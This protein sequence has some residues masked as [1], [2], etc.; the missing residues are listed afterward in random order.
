MKRLIQDLAYFLAKRLDTWSRKNR[1]DRLNRAE[2][3]FE[4]LN[5]YYRRGERRSRWSR[6]RL[7][8]VRGRLHLRRR[9]S[10]EIIAEQVLA[11]RGRSG[12][13]AWLPF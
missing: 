12:L 3:P 1:A 11:R 10:A 7:E 5:P 9:S 13:R 4:E 6:R 8:W 2:G